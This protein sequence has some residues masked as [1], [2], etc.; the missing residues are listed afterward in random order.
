MAIVAFT[1]FIIIGFLFSWEFKDYSKH[2][3]LLGLTTTWGS[4]PY[5]FGLENLMIFACIIICTLIITI[6]GY[7]I[8]D[9]F[10]YE[11]DNVNKPS[12]S[13]MKKVE[14]L[15]GYFISIFIGL[16]IAFFLSFRLGNLYY[17]FYYFVAIILLFFYASHLKA[18]GLLGNLVVAIFS[19]LV[20][21]IIWYVF[22]LQ[23][24]SILFVKAEVLYIFMS[25]IFLT[26]IA[27][28]VIKDCQDIVGDSQFGL[29]TL[30]IKIGKEK[31]VYFVSFFLA[32]L[33]VISG[34]WL[35]HSYSFFPLY[36]NL[37]FAAIIIFLI[38]I[39][40]KSH[41]AKEEQDFK[42]VSTLLKSCMSLGLLYL[43]IISIQL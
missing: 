40:Y 25:F 43:L 37:L 35:N 1:Q 31:A 10:D 4:E 9:Y 23:Y 2:S 29:K 14:L 28:E 11:I 32:T 36:S 30:P 7:L 27:R 22:T 21:A 3:E 39:T 12:P 42:F 17:C 19:S 8:N 26:S 20:I 24:D 13:R 15:K 33:L 5:S 16:L 34:L 38:F 6:G 18:L 41:Q